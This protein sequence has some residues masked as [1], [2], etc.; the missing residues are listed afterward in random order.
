M[1]EPIIEFRAVN[2]VNLHGDITNYRLQYR[3]LNGEWT[4]VPIVNI[5]RETYSD[6]FIKME[7]K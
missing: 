1:K 3:T 6:A 5:P 2:L 7:D 4:D